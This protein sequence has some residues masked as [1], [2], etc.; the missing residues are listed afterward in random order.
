M[1]VF[2]ALFAWL[3]QLSLF[4]KGKPQ[5]L[6]TRCKVN[7]CRRCEVFC[8]RF[9]YSYSTIAT[10]R[11]SRHAFDQYWFLKFWISVSMLLD[12]HTYTTTYYLD[13]TLVGSFWNWYNQEKVEFEDFSLIA[14]IIAIIK[15]IR[16]ENIFLHH[17]FL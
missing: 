7:C 9:S 16:R 13:I 1:Y 4:L 17:F 12:V 11:V 5:L 15:K 6:H 10:L 14:S 8:G 2:Y 3:Q